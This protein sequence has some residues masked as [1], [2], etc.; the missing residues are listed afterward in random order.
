MLP[1][2]LVLDR[3]YCMMLIALI[4]FFG[5]SVDAAPLTSLKLAFLNW[6][7]VS[8]LGYSFSFNSARLAVEEDLKVKYP[9]TPFTFVSVQNVAYGISTDEQTALVQSFI[10]DGFHCIIGADPIVFGDKFEDFILNFTNVTFVAL[11][12]FSGYVPHPNRLAMMADPSAGYFVAGAAAASLSKS[13]VAFI[14]S[15]AE[16]QQGPPNAYAGFLAGVRSVNSTLTVH[17]LSEESWE[18]DFADTVLASAFMEKGCEVIAHY[19]DPR[20]ID[21]AVL[22]AEMPGVFSVGPHS[23]LQEYVGDSVLVAAFPDYKAHFLQIAQDLLNTGGLNQ[24]RYV[25]GTF[26]HFFV[27]SSVSANAPAAAA[28]AFAT[29]SAHVVAAKGEVVC[30][31]WSLAKGGQLPLKKNGC[32]DYTVPPP[33][34]PVDPHVVVHPHFTDPAGCLAGSYYNYS[35]DVNGLFSLS[36]IPCPV[37]TFGASSGM[38][39]C[40]PCSA[41]TTTLAP[42]ATQCHVPA[43]SYS[44]IIE[45]VVPIG[46]CC[47]VAAFLL[48][49]CQRH[50]RRNVRAP[51]AAPLCLLFTDVESSTSLWQKHPDG[52][53]KSMEIHHTVIRRV[54]DTC[55]AYEVK[56][57]GDS[58]MIA[59]KNIVDA[60]IVAN[61]IQRSLREAEWPKEMVCP[62]DEKSKDGHGLR[63]R[64][65]LH[66]CTDLH[67]TYEPLQ[68]YYDYY[69]NDVNISARVESCA[70]GG[71]VL[72]TE[73]TKDQLVLD[74]DFETLLGDDVVIELYNSSVTL[75]GVEKPVNL[76]SLRSSDITATAGSC[77]PVAPQLQPPNQHRASTVPSQNISIGVTGPSGSSVDPMEHSGL[78]NRHQ[79]FSSAVNEMTVSTAF[80][81]VLK[82][83][84]AGQQ[85]ATIR[86]LADLLQISD[87][88]AL[89]SVHFFAKACGRL[90]AGDS[91]GASVSSRHK[92]DRASVTS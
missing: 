73:E 65:G 52:M 56:T 85:L 14:L 76:Y 4:L 89:T 87:R 88:R 42:G 77:T 7:F 16:D 64:I 90:F 5:L 41:G 50:R 59:V 25:N 67:P 17:A 34:L 62:Y 43:P 35:F 40:T 86:S 74:E 38:Q 45:I 47:V 27:T 75:K 51:R 33:S 15:W 6:G 82:R 91:L 53:A 80:E 12:A 46:G 29:A 20:V 13:C 55:D 19:S 3:S 70:E 44:L 49:F 11:Q 72:M 24:S 28:A 18:D 84:P 9:S 78:S 2:S 92:K 22:N 81:A 79:L 71:Q 21:V 30:G 32:Y 26:T 58:F 37:N 10:S 63:V 60:A 61:E 23:N 1:T 68:Q 57:V 48:F 54:I 8:D 36:C 69:G 39:Q 66:Y 31:V 83:I